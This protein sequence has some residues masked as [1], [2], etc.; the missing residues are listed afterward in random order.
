M[1][2]TG[3]ITLPALRAFAAVARTGSFTAAAETLGVS[4]P[5]VS[6]AVARLEAC[7]DAPLLRRE[8]TGATLTAHGRRVLEHAVSVLAAVDGLAAALSGTA[9]PGLTVGF[10]GEAAGPRTA[11]VVDAVRARTEGRVRL[12]R[13]DFDDPTCGLLTGDS[14]LAVVWPPLSTGALDTLPLGADRRAVALPVTHPLAARPALHP[15]DLGGLAWVTP[16]SPDPVWAR[17]RHPAAVG[18]ADA[19]V[20]AGSGAIEETLELVAAGAGAALVSEST[21]QHY[22]RSGVAVVPLL[23]G[24][25]CTTALAW[26]RDDARPAVTETVAALRALLAARPVTG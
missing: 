16:R 9:A 10:M 7:S 25:H 3:D 14:D 17:F 4:Q 21:D 22:A 18:V 13:F 24:H 5:T 19:T 20:A 15:A 6:A 26:R 11:L 1:S 8:R 12:R 23:G 2:K